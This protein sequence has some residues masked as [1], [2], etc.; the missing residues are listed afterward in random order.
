MLYLVP[1]PI[2]NLKDMSFRA[3]EILEEV[4]IILC[5]DTRVSSKLLKHFEI[6]TP[7][8]SYHAHNEHH[9]TEKWVQ[10]LKGG[11]SIAQI[12]DAGTPGISDPG[13]LLVRACHEHN[14][15][16][17]CLPG[18]SAVLPALVMSGLPCNRFHFEGFLPQ[19]KGRQT[20]WKY[21]SEL[22]NTF[23]LYESPFRIIRCLKEAVE[24]LG[25][26]RKVTLSREISKIHEEVYHG[27]IAEALIEFESRTKVRGEFVIVF[28]GLIQKK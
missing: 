4:D 17:T 3:V 5:E 12:S 26:E 7:L 18:A 10:E 8:I 9:Q 19:K 13:F 24:Y 27:T 15:K 21:L 25:N 2:G 28:E 6:S 11:K 20:R 1:T 22:P 14:I 23:A 16:I